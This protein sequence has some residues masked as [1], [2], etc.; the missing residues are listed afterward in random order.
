VLA[1]RAAHENAA[2]N[3][4]TGRCEVLLALPS[5]ADADPLAQGRV[6]AP[7]DGFDVVLANILKPALLDLRQR[8]CGYVRPGGTL[9][10]SGLLDTQ[11]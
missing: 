2:L 4:C 3:D 11:V 10:L 5:M 6:H 9:V 8:L 1:V 7:E